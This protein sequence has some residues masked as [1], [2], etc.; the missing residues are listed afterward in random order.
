MRRFLALALLLLPFPLLAAKGPTDADCLACHEGASTA[1]LKGSVHGEA[2]ASCVDCHADLAK[3]KSF[4]HKK[5]AAPACGSC[6]DGL[7]EKHVFHPFMADDATAV[8]CATCHGSHGIARVAAEPK[9]T[10][11]GL[12]TTCKGCHEAEA[13]EFAKSGHGEAVA[14]GEKEAPTCIS[15]HRQSVASPKAGVTAA[16][17]KSERAKLC[18][19]CH[20]DK[21]EIRAKV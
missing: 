20:L 16:A 21:P 7:A 2:G 9:L 10:G 15:C 18:E 11:K 14:R 5:P 12:V 1:K 8:P 19:S 13:N 6:H 3:A 17:L 4:P